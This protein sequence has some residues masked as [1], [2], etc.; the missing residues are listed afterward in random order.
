MVVVHV[1]IKDG[2]RDDY[3]DDNADVSNLWYIGP[4]HHKILCIFFY[5][6][7]MGVRKIVRLSESVS[8]S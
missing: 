5:I 3:L 4:L 2:D 8:W 1:S 6:I 7:I